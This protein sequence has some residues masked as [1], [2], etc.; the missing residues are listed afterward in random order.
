VIEGHE[1]LLGEVNEAL[2]YVLTGLAADVP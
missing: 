1:S 2:D